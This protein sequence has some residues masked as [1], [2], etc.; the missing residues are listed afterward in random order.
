MA[1][2]PTNAFGDVLSKAGKETAEFVKN[3]V[4]GKKFN[5]TDKAINKITSTLGNNAFGVPEAVYHMSQGTGFKNSLVKTF[6]NDVTE[7]VLEDGSKQ[8]VAKGGYN[9]GKIAGS[10]IGAAAA[11]RVITGGGVYKDGQGRG[12]IIG[13][14]FV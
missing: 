11:G 13:V 14:P 1:K 7:K 9:Y 3:S 8:L 12:N 2:I 10:Y 6:A 4:K 5:G